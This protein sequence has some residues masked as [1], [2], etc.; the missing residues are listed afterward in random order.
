MNKTNVYVDRNLTDKDIVFVNDDFDIEIQ[1]Y[2]GNLTYIAPTNKNDTYRPTSLHFT[3]NNYLI[4]TQS[5][6]NNDLKS[7]A[8]QIIEFADE[9][10]NYNK[11]IVKISNDVSY[12]LGDILTILTDERNYRI[13]HNINQ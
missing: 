12:T 3:L 5:I 4:K 7:L 8:L 2:A 13:L 10:G 11:E 1:L 6:S 9:I